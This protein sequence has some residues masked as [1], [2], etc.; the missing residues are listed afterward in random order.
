MHPKMK[1]VS[2]LEQRLHGAQLDEQM[3][4]DALAELKDK[5]VK[6]GEDLSTTRGFWRNRVT[7]LLL[8][9]L[10]VNLGSAIAGFIALPKILMN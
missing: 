7:R 8:V 3:A 4:Q 5:H 9:Y 10:L 1:Q 2:S 6:L